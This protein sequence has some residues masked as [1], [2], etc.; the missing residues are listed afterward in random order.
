EA[1]QPA[2][3]MA[4]LGLKWRVQKLYE[5]NN[6]GCAVA[7]FNRDG[8]L[9][10]S[11]GEAWYPGPG[12][13]E[14]KPL[15][16]LSPFGEDYLTS[17]AEHARDVNGD[18]WP[19]VVSGSFMEPEIYWYENPGAAGLAKGDLWAKRLL[20]DTLLTRNEWTEKRELDGEC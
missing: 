10:V 7:D 13:K 15:R 1:A 18:G 4:P 17:N 12:F 3:P 20:I 5:Y 8:R 6:E 2:P 11:A 19:D 9:D 16:K 14:R